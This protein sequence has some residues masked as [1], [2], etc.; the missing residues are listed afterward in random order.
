MLG[1]YLGQD[2]NDSIWTGNNTGSILVTGGSGNDVIDIGDF[3][4]DN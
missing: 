4:M 1:E 2:G 3:G